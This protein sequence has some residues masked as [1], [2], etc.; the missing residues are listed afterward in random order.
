MNA[1]FLARKL[2]ACYAYHKR[3][4]TKYSFLN[5]IMYILCTYVWLW[6]CICFILYIMQSF[7]N[8]A[9]QPIYWLCLVLLRTMC[10]CIKHRPE[11][12]KLAWFL[13]KNRQVKASSIIL[14]S[15]IRS[16]ID[17]ADCLI[18]PSGFNFNKSMYYKWHLLL[19]KMVCVKL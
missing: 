10:C 1:W 16:L 6:F 19:Y 14:R 4:F 12:I 2:S 5:N 11:L 15:M 3:T 7:A 13:V 8:I 17:T 9:L 18:S